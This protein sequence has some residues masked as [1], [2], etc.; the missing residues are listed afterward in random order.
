MS[1]EKKELLLTEAGEDLL[2]SE[3]TLPSG[4]GGDGKGKLRELEIGSHAGRYVHERWP[5]GTHADC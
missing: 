5:G 4:D 1:V 3:D 2:A